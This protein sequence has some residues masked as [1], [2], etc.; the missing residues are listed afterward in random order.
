MIDHLT[1]GVIAACTATWIGALLINAGTI[2]G[3]LR[4]DHTLRFAAGRGTQVT[5]QAGA[6]GMTV[7]V[8]TLTVRSTRRGLAWIL[9][10]LRN[11]LDK[12]TRT[13]RIARVAIEA[14]AVGRVVQHTAL[15]IDATG[16]GT[17]ILALVIYT[18][19]RTIAVG[20]L[21]T[22]RTAAAVRISEVFG[23]TGT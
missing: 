5:F 9:G 15:G 20:I 3:T 19:T 7:L 2:L 14:H 6:Y 11:N 18:G 4:A 22:L 23:E 16:A 10:T 8:V 13:M 1:L 17:R 21:H 12:M